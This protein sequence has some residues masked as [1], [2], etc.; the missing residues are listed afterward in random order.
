MGSVFFA[1]F[2]CTSSSLFHSTRDDKF[3]PS[4]QKPW[5]KLGGVLTFLERWRQKES[6]LT[7]T[8]R[9]IGVQTQKKLKKNLSTKPPGAPRIS[10]YFT[11][12]EMTAAA[13][14]HAAPDFRMEMVFKLD[15]FSL[16]TLQDII[17]STFS[18][19]IHL[20]FMWNSING[21]AHKRSLRTTL[22]SFSI[23]HLNFQVIFPACGW[24]YFQWL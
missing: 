1:Q 3:F 19:I 8:R 12:C 18:L 23:T 14:L 16:F 7:D 17:I 2:R 20:I 21:L 10:L 5:E 22:H 15:F 4:W 11:V 24:K 9:R 13:A 6:P